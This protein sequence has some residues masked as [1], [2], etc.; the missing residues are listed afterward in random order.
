MV[1][2]T[3]ALLA[4]LKVGPEAEVLV[5]RLSQAGTRRPA[6]SKGLEPGS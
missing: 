2:D 4:L 3:A 6:T 1:I 5:V